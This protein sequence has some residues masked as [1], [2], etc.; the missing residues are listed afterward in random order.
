MEGLRGEGSKD[1]E[2]S[3]VSVW[4]GRRGSEARIRRVDEGQ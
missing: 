1:H 2:L 3:L 4:R